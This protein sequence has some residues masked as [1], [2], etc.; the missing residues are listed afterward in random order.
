MTLRDA[1]KVGAATIA[2]GRHIDHQEQHESAE[3]VRSAHPEVTPH[4]PISD[5]SWFKFKDKPDG[6]PVDYEYVV[7]GLL[8][9]GHNALSGPR[10]SGK[11]STLVPLLLAIAGFLP[12]YPLQ[13]KLRRQ[14][15]MV[16]EDATQVWRVI[17][18]MR[19]DG[20]LE[21]SF[22]QIKDWLLVSD[23]QRLTAEEVIKHSHELETMM[24]PNPAAGGSNYLAGPLVVLDTVSANLD[25]ENGSNNDDVAKDVTKIRE[26]LPHVAILLIGHTA[27]PAANK[28]GQTF[29]GAQAW[30]AVTIGALT[31]E[32][33]NDDVRYLTSLKNRFSAEH[34]KFK[35]VGN[36]V[37]YQG[38]DA[39]GY[40]TTIRQHY[41]LIYPLTSVEL[42]EIEAADKSAK[43]A[44]SEQEAERLVLS[45]LRDMISESGGQGIRTGELQKALGGR[46]EPWRHAIDRLVDSGKITQVTEGR[47]KH[48]SIPEDDSIP[49]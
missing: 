34:T 23:S 2:S 40:A 36:L 9:F 20:Y 24:T 30:E 49:F 27:K 5:K 44:I 31:L 21:A 16:T 11:S 25:I 38:V 37:E 41:N 28:A 29:L 32:Q 42:S 26:A 3:G 18:A 46:K 15:I 47:N 12:D 39:M 10:G 1:G 8:R 45:K 19:A 48:L 7:E 14:V 4:R 6:I 43:M 33:K 17:D 13:I 35:V 22:E